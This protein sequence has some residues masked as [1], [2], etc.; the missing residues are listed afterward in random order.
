[1]DLKGATDAVRISPHYYNSRRDIDTLV[2]ALEEFGAA[3]A[4]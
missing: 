4:P 3:P 2:V 1:M